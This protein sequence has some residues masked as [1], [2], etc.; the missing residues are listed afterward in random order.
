MRAK[1]FLLL[2]A[3]NQEFIRF[4]N[5]IGYPD[6]TVKGNQI[7]VLIDMPSTGKQGDARKTVL[8]KILDQFQKNY[9]TAL[10]P[11]HNRDAKVLAVSSIGVISF[12]NDPS[13]VLVKDKQKQGEKSSGVANEHELI[14]LMKEQI[15]KFK[16][17]N[18]IFEDPRGKKLGIE[19]VTD[20]THAGKGSGVRKGGKEI[21]KADVQLISP[22]RSLPVSIKQVN[23]GF[24]E[25]ADTLFGKRGGDILQK[26]IKDGELELIED[27]PGNFKVPY[28]VVIEPTEE[29]AM[30]TLFGSD[31][32]PE[33]GIVIQDFQPH[34]FTQQDNY[35]KILCNAVIVT[36]D[37]IPES[38]LMVWRIRN[39]SGRN[40]L[41]IRGLRPEAAT[42]TTALGVSGARDV[43]LVD[44]EGNVK[45]RPSVKSVVAPAKPK[46]KQKLAPPAPQKVAT[47]SL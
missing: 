40:P 19:G 39:A 42:M 3:A 32:N 10:G 34:H 6:V 26:L 47:G 27:P 1:E 45:R 12:E 43:L 41:G 31:I 29:E 9:G 38:H 21:K 20:I 36:R 22:K 7:K 46:A 2:E 30:K 8:N 14:R 11:Y 35:I 23:A 18:V 28:S 33:G 13:Y 25:S 15:D 16:S 17:V 37:D 4:I 44:N 24:W 5:A